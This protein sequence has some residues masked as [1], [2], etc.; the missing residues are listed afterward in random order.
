[1]HQTA[2]VYVTTEAPWRALLLQLS[3]AAAPKVECKVAILDATARVN[4]RYPIL[5]TMVMPYCMFHQLAHGLGCSL[6][7]M[8]AAG[9]ENAD[10]PSPCDVIDALK[11]ARAEHDAQN[12]QNSGDSNG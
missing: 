12:P 8:V 4:G 5:A 7:Q 11:V 1:M 6:T 9:I 3:D 2:G 10:I